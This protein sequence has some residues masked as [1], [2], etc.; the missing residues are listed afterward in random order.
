MGGIPDL[1]YSDIKNHLFQNNSICKAKAKIIEISNRLKRI[2]KTKSQNKY[3]SLKLDNRTKINENI[4]GI[5]IKILNYSGVNTN[6]TKITDE[7]N[8][9]FPQI[10]N[11]TLLP[12][13]ILDKLLE[14]YTNIKESQITNNNQTN[15]TQSNKARINLF[16][17]ALNKMNNTL[18]S[19]DSS[20]IMIL[21]V[22]ELKKRLKIAKFNLL[23]PIKN[24]E[25]NIDII[26]EESIERIENLK[27]LLE[28]SEFFEAFEPFLEKIEKTIYDFSKTFNISELNE[29]LM[30]LEN[31]DIIKIFTNPDTLRNDVNLIREQIM[32]NLYSYKDNFI[33]NIKEMSTIDDLIKAFNGAIKDFLN[34]I[35]ENFNFEE[36]YENVKNNPLF[37]SSTDNRILINL[38]NL[39]DNM[40]NFLDIIK[41]PKDIDKEQLTKVLENITET[42]KDSNEF[43]SIKINDSLY[44]CENEVFEG[45]DN[46][47]DPIIQI[48]NSSFV[49]DYIFSS[50]GTFLDNLKDSMLEDLNIINKAE[51]ESQ[52]LKYIVYNNSL[53]IKFINT[54]FDNRIEKIDTFISEI[55]EY[56]DRLIQFE[57]KTKYEEYNKTVELLN[58]KLKE[59]NISNFIINLN[60]TIFENLQ[61]AS[62]SIGKIKKKYDSLPNIKEKIKYIKSINNIVSE[63]RKKTVNNITDFIIDIQ[64]SKYMAIIDKLSPELINTFGVDVDEIKEKLKALQISLKETKKD[65]INRDNIDSNITQLIKDFGKEIKEQIKDATIAKK[66]KEIFNS[67]V[68]K[69]FF[70]G[71]IIEKLNQTIQNPEQREKYV[72]QITEYKDLLIRLNESLYTDVE[73]FEGALEALGNFS[74]NNDLFN[75]ANIVNPEKNIELYKNLVQLGLLTSNLNKTISKFV[76]M[77]DKVKNARN[78]N[79]DKNRYL[80]EVSYRKNKKLKKHSLKRINKVRRIESSEYDCR[81]DDSFSENKI[82]SIRNTNLNYLEIKDNNNYNIKSG[83]K[84][85][86]KITKDET[87]IC[88]NNAQK[89]RTNVQYKS[90]TNYTLDRNN[91]RFI[92]LLIL[93]YYPNIYLQISSI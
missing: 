60:Q 20:E 84:L 79:Y 74:K 93:E 30:P 11:I 44:S 28:E 10:V 33:K 77:I 8:R 43:F 2:N 41:I 1:N 19:P 57:N 78:F 34:N 24:F 62:N 68:I 50:I 53:G 29:I 16:K 5:L 18:F 83:S 6:I 23:E 46:K 15:K 91:S 55:E 67:P 76:S 48:L 65:I 35:N 54:F 88:Y 59:I 14:N 52:K 4:A 27:S 22:E 3:L 73:T 89:I 80:S 71:D 31:I 45:N 9:S 64:F 90:N 72:E 86:L 63:Q 58:Q 81:L 7:I 21:L 75:L 37:N 12:L 87:S 39:K 40:E 42:I 38:K 51:R 17:S 49:S 66:L 82:L 92:L 32:Q 26:A 47:N 13:D 56:E 61:F 36:I 25:D 70:S 69:K 85:N